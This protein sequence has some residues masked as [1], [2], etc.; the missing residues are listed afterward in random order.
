M[1]LYVLHLRAHHVLLW[2]LDLVIWMD[3]DLA[4]PGSV[5]TGSTAVGILVHIPMHMRVHQM[6]FEVGLWG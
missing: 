1:L 6:D 3:T 2:H 4:F 5:V